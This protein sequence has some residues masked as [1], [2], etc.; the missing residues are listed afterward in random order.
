MRII[1]EEENLNFENNPSEMSPQKLAFIGDAVFEL[2]VRN[3]IVSKYNRNMETL[4]KIKVA[5][6]CSK[7]QSDLFE[8]INGMLT[9][10]EL[11]I[12]K[13][14]RNA[15]VNKI[16]KKISP[17]V[18]HRATGIEALFGFLY[19]NGKFMRLKEFSEK[20]CL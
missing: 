4:N 5:H 16:S 19:L 13:R 7:A 8:K 10:E 17:A 12:Y 1:L 6:V 11:E 15:H 20:I 14:G 2:I 18:Y 9:S 3:K